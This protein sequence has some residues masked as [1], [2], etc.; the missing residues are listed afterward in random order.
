[1]TVTIIVPVYQVAEYIEGCLKSVMRQTYSGSMECLLIDDCGTDDSI[2]IAERMIAA[3]QGTIRFEMIHHERNRGLSAARNTGLD[4][5]TGE[6]V[7]FLDSDDEL[8]DR[9]IE[10]LAGRVKKDESL[11]MVQG[12]TMTHPIENLDNFS[13][14]A[15]RTKVSSNDEVRMSFYRSEGFV[16]TAWNKLIKR[17]FIEE[18]QLRF[19]EGVIYEDTPW[20]FHLLKHLSSVGFV[21]DYTYHYKKRAGSIMTST[22][23][24]DKGESYRAIYR[25]ILSHLTPGHEREEFNQYVEDFSYLNVKFSGVVDEF[26]DDYRDWKEKAKEYGGFSAKIW[27]GA[28]R[29]LCG[30]S[31]GWLVFLL[32]RRV[33]QPGA[34]ITD[35]RRVIKGIEQL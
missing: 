15:K 5:A 11:E 24:K 29:A 16:N 10:L 22:S 6:Y 35:V 32:L 18:H 17:S 31:K 13:V 30:F 25:H 34:L 21:S 26:K 7:L 27:L 20:T 3:Y 8:A 2:G 23:L 33:K 9:C 19:M 1:M 4:H 12:R 28:S 14:K